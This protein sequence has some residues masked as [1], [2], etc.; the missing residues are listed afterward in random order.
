MD[1]LAYYICEKTWIMKVV[2]QLVTYNGIR[3]LPALFESLANQS[4]RDISWR[5]LDNASTDGTQIWLKT[6]AKKFLPH[7]EVIFHKKNIMFTGGHNELFSRGS[8]PF[9]Q[10]IN[11]D[12]ILDKDYIKQ[13]VN[14]L[15]HNKKAGA[16]SGLLCAY[17]DLKN[18]ILEIDSAGICMHRS[19]KYSELRCGQKVKRIHLSSWPKAVNVFGV[20]GT[21]P[22]YRRVACDEFL[23]DP[24]FHM[25]KE[26]VDCARTLNNKG[27][28]S[29]V[30]P[31]AIGFHDRTISQRI[32]RSQ[33]SPLVNYY[34]YRNHLLTLVKHE[35]GKSF[36]K[37]AWHIIP[38]EIA[39]AGYLLM[40]EPQS[41]RAWKDV[42]AY[43]KKKHASEPSKIFSIEHHLLRSWYA[44]TT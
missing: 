36:R 11:Q 20:S 17:K 12:T 6:Y 34:S 25:Y 43:N 16:V 3:Y 30:I 15:T 18:E 7:A 29:Y 14:F 5:I 40:S 31:Q 2:G 42:F 1:S 33:R 38:Y 27:W 4:Y 9:I 19:R 24:D 39:K 8:E 28:Q 10:L 35:T 44:Q 32:R 37:D 26:D 41:L 23:F 13:C 21:L 22:M